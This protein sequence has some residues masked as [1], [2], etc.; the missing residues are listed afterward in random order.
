M[1][2]AIPSD[3]PGGLDAQISEHFGHCSAF[4]LVQLQDG[5]IGQITVLE[6]TAHEQGGCMGPVMLL[7][8]HQVE[9]MVAG[10]M[11]ARPLA[12]FQEVGIA[13]HFKKDAISV[14]DAV[15]LFLDGRCRAFG[16]AQTCSGGG[17][18]CHNHASVERAPIE[19]VANVCNGRVITLDYELRDGSGR[20]IGSSVMSGP[21]R[22]LH[23]S[24]NILRGIERAMEGLEVGGSKRVELSANEAFGERDERRVFEVPLS[25]LPPGIEVGALVSGGTSQGQRIPFTVVE[26]GTDTARLDGNHQ[27]AGKDLVFDIT[28]VSVESATPEEIERGYVQ[29]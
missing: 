17:G 25:Q 18:E 3:A 5:Q 4:T 7:K 6:N 26:I 29:A 28:V 9:A 15:K 19:G 14:A 27:L 24:G 12:G 13:V 16:A 21:M 8:Q 20:L 10:G 1:L 22:Y 11:G 23:G 2:I